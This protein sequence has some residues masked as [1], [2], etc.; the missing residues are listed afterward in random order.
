VKDTT[1]TFTDKIL[2]NIYSDCIISINDNHSLRRILQNNSNKKIILIINSQGGYVSSSD[3]ML[4]LLDIHPHTKCAYV[5]SHAICAATL[6][7]L[8]CDKVY[9]NKYAALGSTDPQIYVLQSMTSFRTIM[10]LVQSKMTD[11]IS[12]EVLI[13]YYTNKIMYDDNIKII[14]KYIDKH[15][16]LN[17]KEDDYNQIINMFSCGDL[18]HHTEFSFNT[19]N[20]FINID[21]K[22][23]DYI[24]QV[25]NLLNFIFDFF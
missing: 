25:Y 6:L 18:A 1:T 11:S 7:A 5:P 9:M 13:A 4:N 15:K 14:Q 12:D 17:I 10:K 16:K 3:S 24:Y 2:M 19:L 22:I 20:K 21:E 23:P 8:A